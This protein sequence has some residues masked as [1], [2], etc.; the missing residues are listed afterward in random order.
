[1]LGLVRVRVNRLGLGLGFKD[2]LL[3][4][5]RE[6]EYKVPAIT[7]RDLVVLTSR[8][9]AGEERRERG[10]EKRKRS[11]PGGTSGSE[12]LNI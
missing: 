4:C 7:K 11:Q 2:L 10:K 8:A 1:M 5:H 9:E 6:Q 12:G 3:F